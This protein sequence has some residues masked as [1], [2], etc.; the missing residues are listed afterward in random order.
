MS[1]EILMGSVEPQPVPIAGARLASS[2]SCHLVNMP[3][4][5]ISSGPLYQE[6]GRGPPDLQTLANS[7][8]Q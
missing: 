5:G 7:R 6:R 8:S 4:P 3:R 1:L 2:G